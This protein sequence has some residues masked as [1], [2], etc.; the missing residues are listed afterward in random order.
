MFKWILFDQA[1][2]LTYHV[3]SQKKIYCV[4]NKK[5]PAKELEKIYELKEH[6]DFELGKIDAKTLIKKFLNQNKLDLT[7]REFQTLYK[8]GIEIIAGTKKLIEMLKN[9]YSLATLINEGSEWAEQKFDTLEYKHFF[10]H[11]IIS[12]NIGLAKPNEKF[13]QKALSIIKAEPKQCLFID[14]QEKNIT[15]AEKCGIK[16]ILFQNPEQLIKDLKFFNIN[17]GNNMD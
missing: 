17:L 12:G 10:K 7:V 11:N 8:Q 6:N 2:V 4:N 14:D 1:N 3:F 13:Y 15:G 16:S 9:Q 5:F